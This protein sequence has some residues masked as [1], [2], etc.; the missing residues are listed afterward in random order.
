MVTTLAHGIEE[1]MQIEQN[2]QHKC[3]NECGPIATVR[4]F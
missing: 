2:F 3:N 4:M 1:K